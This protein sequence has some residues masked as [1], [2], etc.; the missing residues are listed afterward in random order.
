MKAQQIKAQMRK[1]TSF[2]KDVL[3]VWNHAGPSRD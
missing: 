2:L 3:M 1:T